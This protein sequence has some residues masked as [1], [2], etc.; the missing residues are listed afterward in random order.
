MATNTLLIACG[1]LARELV[2]LQQRNEW[3]HVNIQCLPADLHNYPQKI[4]S[5]VEATIKKYK[6]E[7]DNIFASS[8]A[9]TEF[10]AIT[11]TSSLPV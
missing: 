4:P 7:Y 6:A 11:V 5:A 1:A 10:P 3:D 8:T 2:E 9:S